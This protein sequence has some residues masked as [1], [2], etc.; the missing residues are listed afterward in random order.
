MPYRIG[1]NAGSF[2]PEKTTAAEVLSPRDYG[3]IDNLG[4]MHK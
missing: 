1:D 3:T 2:Y 4:L